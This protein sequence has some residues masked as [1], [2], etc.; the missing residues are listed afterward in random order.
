MNTRDRVAKIISDHMNYNVDEIENSTSFSAMGADSLDCVEI[1]MSM[2][3]EFGIEIQDGEAE[4]VDTFGD[5]LGIV[6]KALLSR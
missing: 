3:E 6:E 4:A 1:I 2:E 5:A